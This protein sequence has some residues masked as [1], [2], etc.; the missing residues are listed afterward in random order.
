MPLEAQQGHRTTAG[1]SF[2]CALQTQRTRSILLGSPAK[3]WFTNRPP[4]SVATWYHG[5]GGHAKPTR[6]LLQHVGGRGASRH[7]CLSQ[8][9]QAFCCNLKR[10]RPRR[11][12]GGDTRRKI[13]TVVKWV[14]R[15]RGTFPGINFVYNKHPAGYSSTKY[16]CVS[17]KVALE[18]EGTPSATSHAGGRRH[19]GERPREVRG[20]GGGLPGRE[21]EGA[22]ALEGGRRR[23]RGCAAPRRRGARRPSTS[24]PPPRL[25]TGGRHPPIRHPSSTRPLARCSSLRARS[26]DASEMGG[27]MRGRGCAGRLRLRLRAARAVRERGGL[28]G[29]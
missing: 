18:Q 10:P 11:K 24:P 19:H 5:G 9:F 26:A 22:I 12:E 1:G 20:N 3:S 27:G 13:R 2:W 29:G 14:P 4:G 8:A 16:R 23:H 17:G 7:C 21:E 28:G 6:S 25:L 15:S